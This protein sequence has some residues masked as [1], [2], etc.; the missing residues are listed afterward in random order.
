MNRWAERGMWFVGSIVLVAVSLVAYQ[1]AQ[2]SISSGSSAWLPLLV[3]YAVGALVCGAAV[4]ITSRSFGAEIRSLSLGSV[5]LG[6]AVVGIEFG[7]LQAHRAG[8]SLAV[9]GLVGSAAGA[10]ALAAIGW[11]VLDE[12]LSVRQV[13]GIGLCLAGLGLLLLERA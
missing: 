2:R 9:V 12:T 3:A 5:V 7:Y 13:A 11:L 10:I 4:A 8:W 1:L 6:L